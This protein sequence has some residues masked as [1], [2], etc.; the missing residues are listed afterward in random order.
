MGYYCRQFTY[1]QSAAYCAL[2][3]SRRPSTGRTRDALRKALNE[4]AAA[5]LTQELAPL[6]VLDLGLLLH[7]VACRLLVGLG[8]PPG[9]G[10]L[11]VG[12]LR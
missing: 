5:L 3:P 2:R 6:G 7:R 4:G 8:D 12:G 9:G 10:S 11:V 1:C